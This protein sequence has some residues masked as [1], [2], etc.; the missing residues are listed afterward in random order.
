MITNVWWI[1]TQQEKNKNPLVEGQGV[2]Y[3]Y[4][5]SYNAGVNTKEVY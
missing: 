1:D 2:V 4:F 5:L 3:T